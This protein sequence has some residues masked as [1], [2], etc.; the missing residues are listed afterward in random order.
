[1]KHTIRNWHI[2]TSLTLGVP[3]LLVGLTT[4]FIAHEKSLGTREIA[5]PAGWLG[6]YGRAAAREPLEP[7]ASLLVVDRRWIG[8]RRGVFVE[9]SGNAVA[10]PGGPQDE[11]RGIVRTA[12]GVVWMAGKRGLWRYRDGAATRVHAADCW[13]IAHDRGGLTAACKD[14][15]LLASVDGVRWSAVAVDLPEPDG[16]ASIPLSRIVMDIHTGRLLLGKH[17]EW[18]WIDLLGAVTVALALTGFVMWMRGRRTRAAAARGA[19]APA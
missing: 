6:A 5:V 3:L 8:T 19:A 2:W 14:V 17:A 9:H 16:P 10:L 7:R 18:I 12:D 11:I 4:F 15:G 1:M 13:Q